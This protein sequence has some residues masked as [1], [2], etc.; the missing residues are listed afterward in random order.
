MK[1]IIDRLEMYDKRKATRERKKFWFGFAYGLVC[2]VIGLMALGT[3][4]WWFTQ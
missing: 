3:L 4:I 2:G 1:N